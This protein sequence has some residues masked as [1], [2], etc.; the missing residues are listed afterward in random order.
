VPTKS[1]MVVRDLSCGVKLGCSS[2]ERRSPQEVRVSVGFE[3]A[4]SP[5]ACLSDDLS[6]TI[7]YDQA[8]RLIR[9]TCDERE[10][11]TIEFLARK[12]FETLKTGLSQST[13]LYVEVHKVKPPIDNLLGGVVF[14]YG[15]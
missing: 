12:L 1:S 9:Q 10:Y 8:S 2:E 3:F 13:K 14:K 6:E 7:C 15:E 4:E 11:Q 5:G